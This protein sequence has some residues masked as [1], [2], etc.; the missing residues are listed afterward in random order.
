MAKI[1]F[2]LS[3]RKQRIILNKTLRKN[4]FLLDK[5]FLNDY[6]SKLEKIKYLSFNKK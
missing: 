2:K 1:V 5:K 4:P 6:C 3:I